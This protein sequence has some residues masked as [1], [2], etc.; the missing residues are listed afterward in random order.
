LRQLEQDNRPIPF[1]YET[2]RLIQPSEHH[3]HDTP[4]RKENIIFLNYNCFD[5][6]NNH[7]RPPPKESSVTSTRKITTFTRPKRKRIVIDEDIDECDY[8]NN[9]KR[10]NSSIP[11]LD[12][13]EGVLLK[14]DNGNVSDHKQ[15]HKSSRIQS[16]SM[17]HRTFKSYSKEII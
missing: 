15:R 5:S 9:G 2:G 11:F 3:V 1:D 4:K 10:Q 13:S 7:F 14:E 8:N 17:T 12:I 6:E 16:A